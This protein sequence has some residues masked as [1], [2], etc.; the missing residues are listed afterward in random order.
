MTKKIIACALIASLSLSVIS[1][2]TFASPHFNPSKTDFTDAI[3]GERNVEQSVPG[4]ETCVN[5]I[6]RYEYAEE[7]LNTIN[8]FF[9][10]AVNN[11]EQNLRDLNEAKAFYKKI[12]KFTGWSA[13]LIEKVLQ[14]T[15]DSLKESEKESKMTAGVT[16]AAIGASMA[17]PSAI[18]LVS[19]LQKESKSKLDANASSQTTS[20][21]KKDKKILDDDISDIATTAVATTVGTAVATGTTAITA[22]TTTTTAAVAGTAAA[23]TG[24]T[25]ATSATAATAGTSAPV[26][27]TTLEVVGLVGGTVLVIAGLSLAGYTAYSHYKSNKI[28][29]EQ[30]KINNYTSALGRLYLKLIDQDWKG[31]NVLII[32]FDHGKDTPGAYIEFY[33]VDGIEYNKDYGIAFNRAL[34]QLEEYFNQKGTPINVKKLISPELPGP[35]T[36]PER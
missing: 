29:I 21:T 11:K 10:A 24:T 32:A 2:P 6:M 28:N 15:F 34:N 23:T 26:V 22:G 12:E 18:G 3:L 9:R 5:Y 20:V 1:V 36:L 13:N 35:Q 33:R 25:V 4:C 17:I 14:N 30:I 7:I 16:Q 8:D 27:I 31:N 19:S